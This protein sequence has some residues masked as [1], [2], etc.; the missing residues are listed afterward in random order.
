M[1]LLDDTVSISLSPTQ[2]EVAVVNANTTYC[3]WQRGG[4]KTTCGIGPHLL[5]LSE[6]MPRAQ[7]L[8]VCDTYDRLEKR[9]VPNIINFF[10]E[11]VKLVEGVDFVKYKRPPESFTKPLVPIDN[12]ER[13]I[14]FASGMALCLV[15]LRVEGS[16]NAYNAQAMVC[17]EAKYCDPKKLDTEVIPALRGA[18]DEFGH[19]PEYLS[20]WFFTDKYMDEAGDIY[21]LL[22]KRKKVNHQ[23]VTIIKAL[24]LEIWRLQQELDGCL[25]GSSRYYQ[26]TNKVKA[27][28][29]RANALRKELV[30]VSEMQPY[31]NKAA[32][33]EFYFRSQNR[34]CSKLEFDVAVLNKDPDKIYN[35]FYPAFNDANKYQQDNDVNTDLPFAVAFDHQWRITPMVVAQ[36]DALP[37]RSFKTFNTVAGFH[38]LH[39]E[40]S[41]AATVKLFSEAYKYKRNRTVFYYYDHTAHGK[42]SE[43][44]PF[45]QKVIDELE[46][47]KWLV[48]PQYIGSTP[49]HN[50]R[51]EAFKTVLANNAEG[52]CLFSELNSGFLIKSI[53]KA[54]AYTSGG[55]TQKDKRKEKNLRYPAEEQ[56]DYSDAWDTLYMGHRMFQDLIYC[57]D[58]TSGTGFD[59]R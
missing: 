35:V 56:T 2:S 17:D 21:W 40:G 20:K 1:N 34:T 53:E 55:K 41:I 42:H 47:N 52:A 39:P 27:Y 44:D 30:Y 36:Y 25:Q 51:F 6:K 50:I 57:A 12:F 38:T 11:K 13:V 24:Q 8:L 15:S 43:T 5:K 26:L 33:G 23:A 48:I 14:S 9:V 19:L 3:L 58:T 4:G 28:E 32:V 37:G 59:M 29:E 10:L 31:E 18:Q 22:E 16:A 54:G 49:A 45:Y 46:A 7:I